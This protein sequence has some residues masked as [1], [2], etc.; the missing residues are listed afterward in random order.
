MIEKIPAN[1][2]AQLLRAERNGTLKLV[3]LGVI[4]ISL[5]LIGWKGV[6]LN[7]AQTIETARKR[8]VAMST[9]S[10]VMI[11]PLFNLLIMCGHVKGNANGN[12][13]WWVLQPDGSYGLPPGITAD[14]PAIDNHTG[15][16]PNDPYGDSV[17]NDTGL[18]GQP[19]RGMFYYLPDHLGSTVMITDDSGMAVASGG[20]SSSLS[21]V[22]YTPYGEVDTANS[23]GPDIFHFKYSGQESD[24]ESGLAYFKSRFYDPVLGRF[25]QA[26]SI[27]ITASPQGM[28]KYMFVDGNPVRYRDPNGRNAV[29]HMFGE[30]VKHMIGGV[31]KVGNNVG[32]SLTS[33]TG[34][35]AIGLYAKEKGISIGRIRKRMAQDLDTLKRKWDKEIHS[36]GSDKFA[37]LPFSQREFIE[38]FSVAYILNGKGFSFLAPGHSY[39]GEKN[40]DPFSK[41]NGYPDKDFLRDYVLGLEMAYRSHIIKHGPNIIKVVAFLWTLTYFSPAPATAFDEMS[42]HHDREVPSAVFLSAGDDFNRLHMMADMHALGRMYSQNTWVRNPLDTY[43]WSQYVGQWVIGADLILRHIYTPL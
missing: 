27:Q 36:A 34:Q 22:S 28:S 10:M 25:I 33:R 43:V 7:N 38:M 20:P 13:P 6:S 30:I 4:V 41:F 21:K 39:S 17:S 14:S 11:L 16:D 9:A 2:Y 8:S 32:N 35:L 24:P 42:M 40:L 3:M 15:S 26:D 5:A 12:A 31:L 23:G 37:D 1:V 19:V 18:H 29:A